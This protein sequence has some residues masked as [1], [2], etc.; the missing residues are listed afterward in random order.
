MCAQVR[1]TL[2]NDAEMI[3]KIICEGCSAKY[4]IEGITRARILFS[5][6]IFFC[7]WVIFADA[8][9]C[10]VISS[11]KIGAANRTLTA[12]CALAAERLDSS[13]TTS[14]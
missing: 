14:E 8:A 3:V 6:R 9:H 4:C 12:G 7:Y 11:Q 2:K 5:V 13:V 10:R 1:T